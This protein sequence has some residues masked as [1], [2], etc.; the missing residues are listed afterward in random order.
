MAD[1][2]MKC[3]TC[4][5]GLRLSSIK[6]INRL[7]CLNCPRPAKHDLKDCQSN[8]DDNNYNDN[9]D[10]HDGD[11]ENDGWLKRLEGV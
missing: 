3:L 2:Q 10:N 4:C 6:F 1:G 11:N 7:D 9:Y 5:C 8:N